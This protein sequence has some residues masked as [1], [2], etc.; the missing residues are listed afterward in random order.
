[1]DINLMPCAEAFNDD[2]PPVRSLAMAV[3]GGIIVEDPAR[4]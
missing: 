2:A 1:M 3:L 4:L